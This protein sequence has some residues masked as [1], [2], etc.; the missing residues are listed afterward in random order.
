[1]SAGRSR[2]ITLF[3]QYGIQAA[4]AVSGTVR[5]ALEQYMGGGLQGAA[6][7]RQ[8]IEHGHGEAPA[9]GEYEQDEM[10]RLREEAEMLQQQLDEVV[11]RLDSLTAQSILLE[12]DVA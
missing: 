4:T 2:A 3:Q 1:L 7:C 11:S 6:L 10:G 12:G 5:H 8:S 9:G